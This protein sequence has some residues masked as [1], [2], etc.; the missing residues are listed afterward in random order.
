MKASVPS[1]NIRGKKSHRSSIF[2]SLA[3]THGASIALRQ[4]R[5]ASR[6]LDSRKN[7]DGS[8]KTPSQ[9]K[10]LESLRFN[11]PSEEKFVPLIFLQ[12]D[13]SRKLGVK[14]PFRGE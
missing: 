5:V 8:G 10:V 14:F 1:S 9:I 11:L 13:F 3:E 6:V 2:R 4:I 12:V 7:F